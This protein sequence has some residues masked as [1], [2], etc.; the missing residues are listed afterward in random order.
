[1]FFGDKYIY[2][3]AM[4]RSLATKQSELFFEIASGCALA[5]T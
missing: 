4:I 5:M 1:M 2:V 3:I